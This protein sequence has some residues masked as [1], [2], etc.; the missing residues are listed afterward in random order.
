M[1]TFVRT[2]FGQGT[3]NR[4]R[5]CDPPAWR[6]GCRPRLVGPRPVRTTH[7]R[8]WSPA[9]GKSAR[10]RREGRPDLRSRPELEL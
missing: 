3:A 7:S 5:P 6:S 10:T 9:R 4:A 1:T 8:A 2:E